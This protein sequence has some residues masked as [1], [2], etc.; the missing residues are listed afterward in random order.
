VKTLTIKH[1][2]GQW[3]ACFSCLVEAEPLPEN[4]SAVGLDVG[5]ES[6]AVT[7]DWESI[8]NPRWFGAAQKEL[9]RKQRHVPRCVQGSRGWKRA[10]RLVGNLHRRVLNQRNDFQHKLSRELVNHY[11]FLAL[12]DWRSKDW[13][14]GCWLNQYT[15]P[16]GRPSS[17][18]CPTRLKAPVGNW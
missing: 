13:R 15:M 17:A 4:E 10:W 3:Y 16:R 6:F 8:D 14:A 18:S 5:L 1:E 2:T 12:E 11:G 7:S 9:R